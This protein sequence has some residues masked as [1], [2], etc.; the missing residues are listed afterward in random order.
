MSGWKSICTL[1]VRADFNIGISVDF[2]NGFYLSNNIQ[3]TE[4]YVNNVTKYM[5]SDNEDDLTPVIVEFPFIPYELIQQGAKYKYFPKYDDEF[6]EFV[7]EN[8]IHFQEEKIHP[9]DITGGVTSDTK[10]TFLMQQYF[11]GKATKEQV[12]EE[13][14]TST[15]IKQLCLHKQGYCDLIRPQKAYILGGKELDIYDYSKQR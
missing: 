1:G 3:N 12:I 7:F 11:I 2:G 14:K 10:P 8:R 4:K 15:S 5:V 6:A 9:N 13:L